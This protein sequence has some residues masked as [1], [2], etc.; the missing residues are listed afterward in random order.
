MASLSGV[1]PSIYREETVEVRHLATQL[2]LVSACMMP[3]FSY[4]N[5]SYFTL[6]SG[7]QAMVTFLFD[8]CFQ[9]L[10]CVPVGF[11]LSRFTA[12][13]ILPLYFACQSTDVLKSFLGYWML[14]QGKWI[15]NLT[16]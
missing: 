2:I 16:N 11:C 8:S 15:R 12:I 14:K 5:A 3:V 9:W 10:V 6:R 4:A 13:S 7:G 1:F